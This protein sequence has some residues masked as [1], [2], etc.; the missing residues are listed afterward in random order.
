MQVTRTIYMHRVIT[1][2]LPGE[3]VDHWNLYTLDNQRHNLRRCTPTQNKW[4]AGPRRGYAGHEK[5][6]KFKG[7]IFDKREG[8]YKAVCGGKFLGYFDNEVDAARAYDRAARERH[9]A[10][11]RL[12]FPDGWAAAKPTVDALRNAE[13]L[14][15]E[16][17]EKEQAQAA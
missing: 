9:G 11:A 14:S 3:E 12:N 8:K 15:L 13:Q 16:S 2:A 5:S 7:V 17:C 4:N 10:F 6:S 1:G